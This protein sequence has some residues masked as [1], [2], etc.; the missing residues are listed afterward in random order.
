MQKS[1]IKV[2]PLLLAAQVLMA[3]APAWADRISWRPTYSDA[4]KF[5]KEENKPIM[6]VFTADWCVFC[7]KL[8][9]ETFSDPTVANYVNRN[10]IAV[11]ID[12]DKETQI[13]KD[14][15]V[16]GIPDIFFL[17]P[18]KVGENVRIMA[19]QIGYIKPTPFY[20]GLQQIIA[21]LASMQQI[22]NLA[23]QIK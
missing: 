10:F 23:E 9:A 8:E 11:K 19:R 4:L 2:L 20:E 21:G 12:R 3:A 22:E 1:L 17:E 15:N 18:Y 16:Q 5:S 13:V 7:K 6:M 14:F